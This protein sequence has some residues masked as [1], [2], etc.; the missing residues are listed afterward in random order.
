MHIADDLASQRSVDMPMEMAEVGGVP[1]GE[2]PE[3]DL[4]LADVPMD[5]ADTDD[6]VTAPTHIADP[7]ISSTSHL[8]S[9]S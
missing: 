9:A 8:R 3:A 2:G 6:F 7:S 1:P 5:A 4:E